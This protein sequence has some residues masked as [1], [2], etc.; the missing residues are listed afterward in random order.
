M[1]TDLQELFDSFYVIVPRQE[2]IPSYV[3]ALI[4]PALSKV[5]K[6]FKHSYKFVVTDKEECEGYFIDELDIDELQ[7]IALQMAIDYHTGKDLDR[8]T[9]IKTTIGTKDFNKIPNAS[10]NLK[11]I[12]SKIQMLTD[13]LEQLKSDM[14]KYSK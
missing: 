8:L 7:L 9:S 5:Y 11:N 12:Q 2:A 14:N 13:E 6:Q 3:M 10:E 4:K 1:G